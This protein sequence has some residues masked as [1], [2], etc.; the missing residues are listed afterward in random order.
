MI[1]VS[2]F[3]NNPQRNHMLSNSL[4]FF[5]INQMRKVPHRQKIANV[6]LIIKKG[7]SAT[8]PTG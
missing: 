5:E 4:L 7:D 2:R 1:L 8:N 3:I 6:Y